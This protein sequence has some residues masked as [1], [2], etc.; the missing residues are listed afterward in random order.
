MINVLCSSASILTYK[1]KKLCIKKGEQLA[2]FS[3]LT[4]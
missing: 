4:I 1:L 2:P 3:C